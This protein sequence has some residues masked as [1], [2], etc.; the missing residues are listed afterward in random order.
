MDNN[1]M[2]SHASYFHS[3]IIHK[4][5]IYISTRKTAGDL[6]KQCR[7]QTYFRS[8]RYYLLTQRTRYSSKFKSHVS[9][10]VAVHSFA[11]I[12]LFFF[13]G[14]FHFRWQQ[15]EANKM[16]MSACYKKAEMMRNSGASGFCVWVRVL[17]MCLFIYF[18]KLPFKLFI[19]HA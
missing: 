2:S 10:H 14:I 3:V 4:V 5:S 16:T 1:A 17:N 19:W 9:S 6:M 18:C 11:I 7:H 8:T 12:R 13:R 15:S